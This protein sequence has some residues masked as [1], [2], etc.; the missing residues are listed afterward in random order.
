MIP[1]QAR[2]L[3]KLTLKAV[4]EILVANSSTLRR[5]CWRTLAPQ[6]CKHTY[7]FSGLFRAD[8]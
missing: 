5:I 1:R 6:T 4:S 8:K 2:L 3:K 7:E